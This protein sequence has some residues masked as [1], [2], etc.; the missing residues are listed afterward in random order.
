MKQLVLVCEDSFGVEVYSIIHGINA[1]R[2]KEG[3]PVEYE[4]IGFI[5]DKGNPFVDFNIDI[6]YLGPISE[7]EPKHGEKCVLGIADPASKKKAVE[8]LKS[9]GAV[10]ETVIAP[11]IRGPMGIEIGEGVILSAYSCANGVHIGNFVTLISPMLSG[12]VIGDYTTIMRFAN[13]AGDVGSGSFI[14]N[15]VFLTVEKS[16]G[17]NAYIEDGAIVTRTVKDGQRF[18]GV[19]ARKVK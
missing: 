7:W 4:L 12:H 10:F 6:D 3:K 13:M 16:I 8:S 17:D 5:C 18:T 19:P 2:L 9:R 11:W 14:G 1:E 15:H